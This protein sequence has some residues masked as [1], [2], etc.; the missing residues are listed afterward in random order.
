MT[1]IGVSAVTAYT[2]H[3][4][5]ASRPPDE[6]YASVDALYEAACARRD[7]TEA[8]KQ[9]FEKLKQRLDTNGDGKISVDELKNSTGRMKFDDPAAVD[10]DHDGFISDDELRAAM[11]ARREKMK[12]AG[13][14]SATESDEE[15]K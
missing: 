6:R 7:R 10:T 15:P 11:Q 13:A 2:A 14:G 12:A 1:G 4:E 9:R 5:W 8:R 3:R